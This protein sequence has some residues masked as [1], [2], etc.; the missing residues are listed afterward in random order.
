[1]ILLIPG[2]G[3][4]VVCDRLNYDL[5]E[6]KGFDGFDSLLANGE[7]KVFTWGVNR[8]YSL[9][10]FVSPLVQWQL[11]AEEKNLAANTETLSNLQNTL[12][13]GSFSTIVCHSLGA[14]VLVKYLQ[15]RNLTRSVKKVVFVQACVDNY[16][17]LES[18]MWRQVKVLKSFTFVN[19]WCWW[20]QA[21]IS[22]SILAKKSVIGLTPDKKLQKYSQF[23]PLTKLWNLHTS[24]I[25]NKQTVDIC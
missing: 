12:E 16:E 10:Q 5:T 23:L 2:Y 15:E 4:E 22:Y 11:F 18:R 1:M 13:E 9:S 3:V 14:L 24:S 19:Y 8:H 17:F 25:R 7:A 20:D 6:T 21:L